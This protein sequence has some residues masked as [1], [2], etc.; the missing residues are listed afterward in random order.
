MTMHDEDDGL[1]VPGERIGPFRLGQPA[2]PLRARLTDVEEEDRDGV[3][4]LET[5]DVSLFVEDGALTQVGVHGEHPGRTAGGLR[6][7]MTLAEVE[8][9]LVADLFDEVLLLDGVAGLCFATDEGLGDIDDADPDEELVLE[10]P[11]R[12]RITWIGVYVA[13]T[14]EDEAREFVAVALT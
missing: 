8:G 6:L 10:L 9:K 5:R 7:G 4:V 11:G 1:I 12:D 14:G 3:L 13:G 2:G